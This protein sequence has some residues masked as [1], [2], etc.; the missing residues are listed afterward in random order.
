MAPL[1]LALLLVPED[2]ES[3]EPS[4]PGV[5]AHVRTY[6]ADSRPYASADVKL[7]ILRARGSLDEFEKRWREP[8]E[9]FLRNPRDRKVR[10]G[11]LGGAPSRIVEV[12]RWYLAECRNGFTYWVEVHLRGGGAEGLWK[13]EVDELMEG[14]LPQRR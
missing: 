8:L 14:F 12:T 13:A 10:E 7:S 1:L 4:A 11:T 5:E 2:W 3:V 6:V 9:G